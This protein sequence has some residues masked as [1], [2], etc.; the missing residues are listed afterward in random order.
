MTSGRQAF[1]LVT[2]TSSDHRIS[3]LALEDT[4]AVPVNHPALMNTSDQPSF[5]SV[6]FS[7]LISAEALR[8]SDISPVPSL[9]LQPN[10]RGGT[11]KEKK[12]S[13]SLYRKFVGQLRKIKSNKPLYPKPIGL[14]RIL[15]LVLQKERR[16]GLPRSNSV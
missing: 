7:P 12:K 13:N 3:P 9:N 2:R 10:T 14:R 1:F 16:E 15:F 11:A 6:Y 5:T 8:A 4:D